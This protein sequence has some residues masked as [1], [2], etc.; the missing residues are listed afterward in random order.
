MALAVSYNAAAH[1]EETYD[2]QKPYSPESR[3]VASD[4]DLWDDWV[5]TNIS[6]HDIFDWKLTKVWKNGYK[7]FLDSILNFVNIFLGSIIKR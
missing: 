3:Q 5:P 1:V 6:R 4:Q 2:S 7:E